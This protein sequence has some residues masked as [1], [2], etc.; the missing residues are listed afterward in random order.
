MNQYTG[1]KVVIIE[2]DPV[3][4]NGYHYLIGDC[5]G[6]FVVN[7]YGSVEAFLKNAAADNPDVILLD[8]NLPGINGI[9]AIPVIKKELPKVYILILTVYES[10]NVVF[11]ALYNGASGYLTKNT[12]AEVIISAIK[13]VME[14]GGPMSAPIARLVIKSFQK[15]LNSPLSKREIQVLELIAIGKSRTHIAKELFV[16]PAT[17][18]THIKNIYAKLHVHSKEDA[19]KIALENQLI[20]KV[21]FK[22]K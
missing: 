12:A 22:K 10:E 13:E 8:I 19:L 14:G 18:K 1:I 7:S 17:I 20:N 21:S 2:D 16:E 11:D 5:D 4:R 3:I 15:N 6:C 9:D